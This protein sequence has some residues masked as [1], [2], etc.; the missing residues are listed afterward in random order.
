MTYNIINNNVPFVLI[1]DISL[2]LR[3]QRNTKLDNKSVGNKNVVDNKHHKNNSDNGVNGVNGDNDDIFLS[4]SI[5]TYVQ[6]LKKEIDNYQNE[7]DI[8]KKYV[9]PYEFIHTKIPGDKVAVCKYIPISRS[10][11]KLIEIFYCVQLN[12]TIENKTIN[13]MHLAEAPGGFME[14]IHYYA[15]QTN[16]QIN[17]CVG[18]SLNGVKSNIPSWNMFYINTLK[19][20]TVEQGIHNCDLTNSDNYLYII[21]KY[22][23]MYDIIT[24]DGGFDFSCDFNNQETLSQPLLISEMLYAVSLQKPGGMFILKI[25]DCFTK[26]SAEI[27]YIL[28]SFYE[29]IY[30]YKPNTSRPANSEKYII[31]KNFKYSEKAR[32]DLI[33]IIPNILK[34]A[35]NIHSLLNF[36][37][38]LFFVNKLEEIN[39]ILGQ[40]QLETISSTITLITHKSQKDKLESLKNNNIQKCINWCCKHNFPYNVL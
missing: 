25:F 26:L 10:F 35:Y 12:K 28:S 1:K 40:Q 9:N 23:P 34:N 4:K 6:Q 11:F 37:L 30:I 18:L 16:T 24:A 32:N 31:C 20:T 36:D 14:A 3:S 19:N 8:I 33:T 2:V 13:T 27:I 15:K 38:P 5:F 39:A 29:K 21:N 22:Q 7:W 17:S